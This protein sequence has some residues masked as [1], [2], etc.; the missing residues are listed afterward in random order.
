MVLNVELDPDARVRK[1]RMT[2][3]QGRME[4]LALDINEVTPSLRASGDIRHGLWLD[5]LRARLILHSDDPA[6][7]RKLVRSAHDGFL[8]ATHGPERANGIAFLSEL[9][10]HAGH[11]D[12]ATELTIMAGEIIDH[13]E[14]D[15]SSAPMLIE[16]CGWVSRSLD[17]LGLFE[18]AAIFADRG[19]ELSAKP[20]GRPWPGLTRYSAFV[21]LLSAE[22]LKRAGEGSAAAEHMAVAAARLGPAQPRGTRTD[23]DIHEAMTSLLS[24]WLAQA[25]EQVE[26]GDRLLEQAMVLGRASGVGWLEA[27]ATYLRGRSAQQDGDS[28]RAS[29]LLSEAAGGLARWPWHRMSEWCLLDL[30][31]LET[32]RGNDLVALR[33]VDTFLRLRAKT[34]RRRQ[35][36]AKDLFMRRVSVLS[37][38]RV[39][40]TFARHAIE[41][42]LT[43]LANRRE[44]EQ[45]LADLIG[46]AS[47]M[48]ICLAV[49][50]IDDFK[51]V[52]DE[53]SH[54]MGDAVLVRVAELI[55]AN[56]HAEDVVARWAGDEF[57]VVMPTTSEQEAFRAM[58]RLR[59]TVS[60][61]EWRQLGLDLPVSVSIGVTRAGE[62][63]S[64][65]SLFDAADAALFAAKRA[66]RNRVTCAA[67][68][69]LESGSTAAW[70]AR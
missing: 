12:V 66:G 44:A 50:D 36:L 48:P 4:E 3:W 33:W 53:A 69:L 63:S 57:V 64:A 58:E 22:E 40:S 61:H 20:G 51:R 14:V 28:D 32:E 38:N 5:V 7:A 18:P 24:G 70:G 21:H 46:D 42:P 49:V 39:R 29:G 19:L 31:D 55:D 26:V 68:A 1:L 16:A 34:H 9:Y 2:C 62:D 52:N 17:T 10:A 11:A 65:R 54:T 45:R 8:S 67:Q 43:G 35:E 27:A 60:E 6:G 37:E 15:A 56:S 25:R 59:R 13:H 47:Q 41:D 23:R 30:I